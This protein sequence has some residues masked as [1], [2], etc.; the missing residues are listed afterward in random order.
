MDASRLET[1]TDSE[2]NRSSAS[3]LT[4]AWCALTFHAHSKVSCSF[5][6]VLPAERARVADHAADESASSISVSTCWA[7]IGLLLARRSP[8]V[9]NAA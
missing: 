4:A 6:N 3:S 5:E 8:R 7:P 1:S 9:C 2:F